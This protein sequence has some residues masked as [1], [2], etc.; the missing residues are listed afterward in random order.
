M[1]D[2]TRLIVNTLSQHLRTVL[3]IAMS[4]YSTR[5]VM[6]AL[7][8]SNYGVYMLIGGIVSL[9]LYITNSMV[10]TTQ[11]H[12][13]YSYGKG[14][15][16]QASLIFQNSYIL[17]VLMGAVI[18][19]CFLLLTPFLF[20]HR[21]LNIAP[22]QLEEAR[23]VYYIVIVNVLLTFIT[24]P[25]R[26]LLTA[27]ENI[28]YISLVDIVDGMLK[29]GLVFILFFVAEYR[30]TI[31]AVI[32]AS[33]MLFNFLALS[34]YSKFQYKEASL[35]PHPLAFDKAVQVQL[36][37]F[38]TWTLYGTMCV[39]FRAQGIAI[40]INRAFGTIMNAAYGIATQ[41]FGAIQAVSA[42]ILNAISPQIIKAEGNDDRQ[43]ML[44]LSMQACKYSFL[45]LAFFGIPLI[46]E[47]DGILRIW[48][49]EPPAGASMFCRTFIIASLL[50]QTT[51]GLNV[52]IQ[53]LGKIRNYTLM[54]YTVKLLTV[55]AV[56]LS[57]QAGVGIATAMLAYIFFEFVAAMLRLPYAKRQ[58]ALSYATFLNMVLL[59]IFLP[60][61]AMILAC[62][63]MCLLPDFILRFFLT[64]ITS[65]IVG[66]MV[67]WNFSLSPQEKQY[68]K[69]AIRKKHPA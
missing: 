6:E 15:A 31:Y 61:I 7:G 44:Y 45:L 67:L 49:K 37:G 20:E 46:F 59:K 2:T 54:L 5:L 22:S 24:T 29:L 51:I 12:L 32:L 30:L 38:A 34:V 19:V 55:L 4:L 56:W 48:L 52:S 36:I 9:L 28:V 65:V 21:L 47:M 68:I 62:Y 1:N 69:N 13:S 63:I 17:H 10:V 64:G 35:L 42:A 3:N 26:A 27:R 41:V 40:I 39:F 57:L 53:A 11:R 33:V 58:V 25:F 16:K 43:R 8:K 60:T 14:D 18:S 50:D 23:Y 66:F